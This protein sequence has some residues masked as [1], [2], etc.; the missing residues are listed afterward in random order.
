MPRGSLQQV[1]LAMRP[2]LLRLLLARQAGEEAEDILQELYLKLE[3]PPRG[4]IG[5]APA[6]LYRMAE[7]LLLDRRRSKARAMRRDQAWLST[8]RAAGDADDAPDAERALIARERLA[9]MERALDA[10]PERCAQAF[11]RFRVDG[12]PQRA[13][14]EELGVSLS[15]IEKDLQRAYRAV[16]DAEAAFDAEKG[17]P[18]RLEGRKGQ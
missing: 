7:N 14:A 10:L 16:L 18:R 15:A 5:D 9:T 4:P 11:R 12:A 2:M 6:Y 8:H 13:I 17:A 3:R 1:Y